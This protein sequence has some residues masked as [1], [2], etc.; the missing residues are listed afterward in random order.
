MN[1]I[2]MLG[3]VGLL[4]GGLTGYAA[5]QTIASEE[6]VIVVAPYITHETVN[7]LGGGGGNKGVYDVNSLTRDVSYSDLDLATP[8]GQDML[9]QRINNTAKDECAELKAKFPDPP[10]APVF[11]DQDC[12]K[13]ATDQAMLIVNP[14]IE[15]ARLALLVPAKPQQ[16][17]QTAQ[18][19]PEEPAPAIEAEATEAPAPTAPKQDRN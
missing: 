18:V 9:I 10:H 13:K 5:A 4:L 15:R 7:N 11:S 17:E 12:V 1:K 6:Q 16:Q 3:S 2:A 14:L 19:I 8:S